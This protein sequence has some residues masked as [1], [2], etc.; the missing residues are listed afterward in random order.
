MI[1]IDR[2]YGKYKIEDPLLLDL[3]NSAPIQRLKKIAQ[4][5]IPD[6]YYHLKNY[7]RFEHSIGVMI[8]LKRL[9]A[10]IEE[11]AAGLLHDVSHT[12]FSHLIDW[13]V[14]DGTQENFQDDQH[15]KF[16][17]N[18]S[19]PKIIKKHGYDPRKI[20]NYKKFTL[21]EQEIPDLCADRVDYSLREFNPELVKQILPA[22][23][24]YKNKII[25][26]NQKAAALFAYS[27]LEKQESHWGGFE[28]VSRYK[29]FSKLLKIALAEKIISEKDFW[30]T[31]ATIISKLEKSDNTTIREFLK[32]MLNKSLEKFPLSGKIFHKKFRHTDP[33]VL[34]SGKLK[35]L[36]AIDKN[37]SKFLSEAKKR[38]TKGI[39]IPIL[40]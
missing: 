26:T 35:K 16:F 14:G 32:S 8:L 40:P 7:Y 24:A 21:L 23:S 17:S 20:S 9:G 36:S 29:Y 25:F 13:V 38:N 19:L 37:F 33:R 18:S 39:Q 28:A 3:I 31:D 1:I 12:A 10:G 34:I 11:Q 15:E 30:Q 22:L 6:K 4:Y 2:I 5:G 27:F